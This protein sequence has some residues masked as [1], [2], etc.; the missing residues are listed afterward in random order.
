[1]VNFLSTMA[2]WGV[3]ALIA[4]CALRSSP[5]TRR[6]ILVRM[7][8]TLIFVAAA[9][10]I[11][12]LMGFFMSG[13]TGLLGSAIVALLWSGWLSVTWASQQRLALKSGAA[14]RTTTRAKNKESHL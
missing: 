3:L 5:F 12:G 13:A 10:V 2:F 7:R 4:V 1:M 11:S 6:E 8:R 9:V 14:A